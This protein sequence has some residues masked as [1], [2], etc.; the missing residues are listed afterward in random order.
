MQT[1]ATGTSQRLILWNLTGNKMIPIK[2]FFLLCLDKLQA[3]SAMQLVMGSPLVCERSHF[4]RERETWSTAHGVLGCSRICSPV[5][6]RLL[7]S[8]G[9]INSST[10]GVFF[11]ITSSC[12]HWKGGSRALA[13]QN[14]SKNERT[15][16]S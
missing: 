4:A 12:H 10:C 8:T 13:E 14:S 11:P 1:S 9:A 3:K 16:L 6:K 15:S 7:L 5:N 2:T